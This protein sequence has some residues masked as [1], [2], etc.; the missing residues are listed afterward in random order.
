MTSPRL[1][2]SEDSD[3]ILAHAKRISDATEAMLDELAALPE[4]DLFDD[5]DE[6]FDFFREQEV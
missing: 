5:E 6:P 4:L 1:S 2:Y 3:A